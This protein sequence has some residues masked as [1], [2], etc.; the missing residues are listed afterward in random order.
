MI[1]LP[2]GLPVDTVLLIL[3]HYLPNRGAAAAA[4]ALY[5]LVSLAAAAITV[6]T[7]CWYMLLVPVTAL[8]EL[9]GE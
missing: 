7:R 3:Y 2:S 8:L 5:A 9:A 4:V 6:K 1:Q